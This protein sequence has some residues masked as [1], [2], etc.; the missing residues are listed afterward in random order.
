MNILIRNSDDVIID[1]GGEYQLL[2]DGI[3]VSRNNMWWPPYRD[4]NSSNSTVIDIPTFSYS[5]STDGGKYC[6]IDNQVVDN[7]DYVELPEIEV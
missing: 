5:Q 2:E 1:A 4:L 7:P 3:N 6:W